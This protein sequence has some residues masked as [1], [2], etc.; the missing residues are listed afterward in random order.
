MIPV[1]AGQRDFAFRDGHAAAAR[2]R[3]DPADPG[4]GRQKRID[5]AR[6]AADLVRGGDQLAPSLGTAGIFNDADRMQL[7]SAERSGDLDET[8]KILSKHYDERSRRSL[9]RLVGVFAGVLTFAVALYVA[10]SV[11]SGFKDAVLGPLELLE[12]SMPYKGR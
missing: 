3:R 6:R 4:G 11:V 1:E 8:F 2:Q 12:E 10:M 7:V 9:R 5:R